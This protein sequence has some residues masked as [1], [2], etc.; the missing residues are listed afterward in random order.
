MEK[1]NGSRIISVLALVIAVAG[2]SIGFAAYTSTLHISANANVEINATAAW[3]VG[4]ALANGTMGNISGNPYQVA[5]TGPTSAGTIDLYKYTIAQNTAATLTNVSGSTVSYAFKI[6]ND[7]TINADLTSIAGGGLTC[8][9]NSSAASRTIEQ[10]PLNVGAQMTAESG[11]V[12]PTDCGTMFN[13]T[14]TIDGHVYD[15]ETVGTPSYTG[16]TIDAGDSV[17][18]TLTISATGTAPS[19]GLLGDFI[20][21]LGAVTVIYSSSTGS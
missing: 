6:K 9:Y 21:T 8:A 18:A 20:V 15:V 11:T 19:N 3:N 12:D 17:D 5:G 4:F 7:G 16:M 1:G 14:L 13:A 10:D 2:L